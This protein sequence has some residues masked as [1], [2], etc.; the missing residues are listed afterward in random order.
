[1]E[2]ADIISL[3][4]AIGA[5]AGGNGI[6]QF[7]INR[8]DK[9]IDES[10]DQIREDVQKLTSTLDDKFISTRRDICKIQL[11]MLMDKG[12]QEVNATLQVA[13]RYFIELKGNAEMAAIFTKW[14]NEN[15]V[16]IE[17]LKSK[18]K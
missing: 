10:I 1:M 11:Q 6:V 17:Y 12:D 4:V 18:I 9:K 2:L 3:I 8:K 7:L 16:D 5:I 15:D 13:E 14:A